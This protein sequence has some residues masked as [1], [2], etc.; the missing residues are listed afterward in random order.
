MGKVFKHFILL[1][2]STI[3]LCIFFSKCLKV[4]KKDITYNY[5]FHYLG[6]AKQIIK[7]TVL[8]YYKKSPILVE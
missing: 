2:E 1:S 4:S 6:K 8:I 3:Y 5:I 7:H